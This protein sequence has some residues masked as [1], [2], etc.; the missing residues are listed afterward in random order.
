MVYLYAGIFLFFVAHLFSATPMKQKLLN[1][2]PENL[3]KG[4]FSLVALSGFVL[5]ILGKAWNGTFILLYQPFVELRGLVYFTLWLSLVFIS[6]SYSPSYLTRWFRHPMLIGVALWSG[7]HLL[8]NG[9]LASVWLFGSFFAY[10][11]TAIVLISL[12][13]KEAA[14]LEVF[15]RYDLMALVIGTLVYL[16]FV[17]FLHGWLFGLPLRF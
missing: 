1:H 14:A 10:S 17:F 16:A 11:I 9:D 2:L 15:W 8:M 3:Y 6:A 5:I 13:K 12:R 7:G 4:L